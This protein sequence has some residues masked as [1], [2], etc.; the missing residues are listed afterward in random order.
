[1]ALRP[2][3]VAKA[4][5]IYDMLNLGIQA[6][7]RFLRNSHWWWHCQLAEVFADEPI[8]KT[9]SP[10]ERALMKILS[11]LD[12]GPLV[13]IHNPWLLLTGKM[14]TCDDIT[15]R[16]IVDLPEEQIRKLTLFCRRERI[17]RAEAIRRAIGRYAVR[18]LPAIL[19]H[20][21]ARPDLAAISARLPPS[22]ANGV[23]VVERA[24]GQR[25]S[26]RFFGRPC[27]CGSGNRAL[28]R[29]LHQ[30]YFLDGGDGRRANASG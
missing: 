24:V 2:R 23:G 7:I 14:M 5:C 3:D 18:H 15:V 4:A 26:A 12:T 17:S 9:Y 10:P 28:S 20:F 27:S 30:H 11:S 22:V 29:V 16:T 25:R 21:L 19:A 6:G 13:G 1:M 8:A